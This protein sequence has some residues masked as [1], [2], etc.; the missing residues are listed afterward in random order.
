VLGRG[1]RVPNG[2]TGEQP[3]VTVFNHD[4]WAPGIRHLVNEILEIEK[5]LSSHVVEA[6]PLHFDLHNIN[7]ELKE[8]SVKKPMEREYT[9]FAKGY[10]DLATDSPAEDVSIE[11]ERATTGERYQWQTKIQHKTYTPRQVAEEMYRRLEE[12]QE[13]DDP[14][15]KRRTVYTD[16]FPVERLEK[17]VKESLAKIKA[18]EATESMKQNF[19]SH[20]A[21]FGVNLPRTSATRRSWIAM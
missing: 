17:I 1:L 10:V 13:A 5:R 8:T 9:L 16:K 3:E 21:H 4:A 12:A 6:S 14:D 15:P 2:W 19:S 11:F 20:W 7:Y 18:K